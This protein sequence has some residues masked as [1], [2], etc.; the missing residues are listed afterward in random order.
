MHRALLQ[1]HDGAGDGVTVW[2]AG[3][4]RGCHESV[5][6]KI[7]HS[8]CFNGGVSL[9]VHI[10][11]GAPKAAGK[12][13]CAAPDTATAALALHAPSWQRFGQLAASDLGRRQAIRRGKLA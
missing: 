2:C 9:A 6:G 12:V 7:S 8:Q 13:A 1:G 5:R 11:H 4:L 3:A 10:L